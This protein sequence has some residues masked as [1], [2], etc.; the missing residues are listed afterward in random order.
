MCQLKRIAEAHPPLVRPY[1]MNNSLR[2]AAAKNFAAELTKA[3]DNLN[4]MLQ[5]LEEAISVVENVEEGM[6]PFFDSHFMTGHHAEF[7]PRAQ[8][9]L[10]RS[11]QHI[12][13]FHDQQCAQIEHETG[14]P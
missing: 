14:A 6:Y 12:G 11:V 10:V 5:K 8:E 4:T 9:S 1:T 13:A 7:L 3:R 2:R